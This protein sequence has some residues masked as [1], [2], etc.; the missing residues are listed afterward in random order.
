MVITLPSCQLV[1]QPS[2]L[3]EAGAPA[4]LEQ[5]TVCGADRQRPGLSRVR[6]HDG[7]A[8]P[9]GE[10][11][12]PAG[13]RGLGPVQDGLRPGGLGELGHGATGAVG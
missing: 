10:G 4:V 13:Q 3:P 11:G 7:L 12:V 2:V 5:V 6:P 1:T 9:D 8:Q